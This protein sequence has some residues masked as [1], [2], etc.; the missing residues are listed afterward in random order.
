MKAIELGLLI[1]ILGFSSCSKQ[2]DPKVVD[3]G[4]ADLTASLNGDWVSGETRLYSNFDGT[5]YAS[6]Y[7]AIINCDLKYDY[8]FDL[9][10]Q[11]SINNLSVNNT[12]LCTP[13]RKTT[14]TLKRDSSNKIY[15]EEYD[16]TIFRFKYDVLISGKALTLTANSPYG[17]KL[18]QPKLAF[19]YV[20]YLKRK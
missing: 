19:T 7:H 8:R 4:I 14:L 9:V 11:L 20:V 12:Y 5:A 15:A 1:I 2:D 18:F 16:G 3:Q 6:Y 13:S 10:E 17:D